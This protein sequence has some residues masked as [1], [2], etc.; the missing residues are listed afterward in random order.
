MAA[1]TL[2][3]REFNQDTGRAKK[4]AEKDVVIITDRGQPS[5]VLMSISKYRSLLES[6][7]SIIDLL[8]MPG[9]ENVRFDPRKLKGPLARPA[10]FD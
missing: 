4:S 2:S 9:I 10:D 3:S 5:H 1:K 6:S 8:G 7:A